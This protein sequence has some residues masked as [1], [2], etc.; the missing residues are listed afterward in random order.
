[1]A[2]KR[3]REAPTTKQ[4]L[5]TDVELVKA[6]G[7]D[8]PTGE[9]KAIIATLDV[10]DRHGDVLLPGSVGKQD[11]P[12]SSYNHGSWPGFS[13]AGALPIGKGTVHEA[14]NQ[15]GKH[16]VFEGS[17]F[18]DMPAAAEHLTLLKNMGAMQ[19]WSFQL[20]DVQGGWEER[21]GHEVFAIKKFT[22]GEVSPVLKAASIGTRT[23]SVKSDEPPADTPDATSNENETENLRAELDTARKE[24][25][26][27]RQK[28]AEARRNELRVRAARLPEGTDE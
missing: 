16:L 11:V 12:I 22:V 7:G 18:V 15:H 6:D 25:A 1:M 4:M 24:N 19:Q 17:L 10:V 9:V 13:G 27:L 28:L 21:D 14:K 20:S 23:V 8:E 3:R 26:D 2:T 5:I